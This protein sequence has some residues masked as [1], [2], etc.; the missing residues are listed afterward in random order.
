[1][2]SDAREGDSCRVD[3]Q[4]QCL[5][6]GLALDRSGHRDSSCEGLSHEA[7]G[8]L[9]SRGKAPLEARSPYVLRD[10]CAGVRDITG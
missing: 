8:L 6:R 9:L 4:G 2:P 1:M 5:R 10:R 3:R 7:D